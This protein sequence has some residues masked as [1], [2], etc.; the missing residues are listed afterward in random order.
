[1]KQK[2]DVDYVISPRDL[3]Y[4]AQEYSNRMNKYEPK[5]TAE[6]ALAGAL[7]KTILINY[8][9]L[10]ERQLVKTSI[11]ETFGISMQTKYS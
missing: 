7:E 11:E 3:S 10:Q 6:Q 8:Q 2:Q 9:D 1:M 5:E 4:F